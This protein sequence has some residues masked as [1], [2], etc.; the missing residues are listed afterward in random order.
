MKRN[1]IEAKF[2]AGLLKF[3]A[4]VDRASKVSE[5]LFT[6]EGFIGAL[7]LLVLLTLIGEWTS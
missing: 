5:K 2:E 4:F 7:S 6:K 3:S 1:K